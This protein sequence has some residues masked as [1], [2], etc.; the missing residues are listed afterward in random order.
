ML[1]VA[2]DPGKGRSDRG[3]PG[4]GWARHETPGPAR[5]WFSAPMLAAM[6]RATMAVQKAGLAYVSL[7]DH[8]SQQIQ[9]SH[10]V[11]TKKDFDAGHPP[12]GLEVLLP[13]RAGRR[14]VGGHFGDRLAPFL[15]RWLCPKRR[16]PSRERTWGLT[17]RLLE[18]SGRCSRPA[19]PN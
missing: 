16:T 9:I 11:A 5:Y 7:L 12:D 3:P 10:G 14:G 19:R 1:R 2:P 17:P 6:R 18:L 13:S 15:F 8:S 4:E